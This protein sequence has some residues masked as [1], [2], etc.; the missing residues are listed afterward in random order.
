MFEYMLGV[1]QQYAFMMAVMGQVIKH[2]EASASIP[3]WSQTLH[4]IHD[5]QTMCQGLLSNVS[6]LADD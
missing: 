6:A 4:D 1:Q 5:V 2:H 3:R